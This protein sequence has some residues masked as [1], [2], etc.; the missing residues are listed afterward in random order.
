MPSRDVRCVVW[1]VPIGEFGAEIRF[2]GGVSSGV[3][4]SM[5]SLLYEK[6]R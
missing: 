1:G 5:A 6:P 4:E 3:E 2:V